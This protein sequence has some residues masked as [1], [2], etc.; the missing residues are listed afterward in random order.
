MMV[1]PSPQENAVFTADT[2]P[3]YEQATDEMTFN[4]STTSKRG[5]EVPAEALQM[6]EIEKTA[7]GFG[8]NI[9]GGIDNP[10]FTGDI[11]IYVSSVNHQSKSFGV[12]Q[13]GDKILSF[14]GIDM[15][16][17][18]HDEAVDVF[19]SMKVGHVAKML[20]DRE[21]VLL[22]ED[23][24]QSSA[25]PTRSVSENVSGPVTPQTESTQNQTPKSIPLSES[26]SRLT[27]H[28]F[29]A[30]IE[31]IR[32]KVY[33]EEDAQSVTSYA[34]ST[35]SIIDDVPRTPRKPLSLLDPRNNSWITEALYVSIGLG[36]LTLSGFLV[37]RFIKGRKNDSKMKKTEERKV[38]GAGLLS[39]S[40]SRTSLKFPT[41]AGYPRT[42]DHCH[43]D[44]TLEFQTS[45][46]FARHIR[47]DHTT[48]EGGSFLCRYG[49][50]GVC[51]KL[52]LEGVCDEDFEAHIRRCH[53]SSQPGRQPSPTS[54]GIA[55][56][57]EE[58]DAAS[59][60]SVRLTSE[61]PTREKKKFTLHR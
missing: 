7:N 17:K 3:V 35:H 22:Q 20:I 5:E 55:S 10:H 43:G 29:S 41:E 42:C 11:G 50:H 4:D 21:Y 27:A 24:T 56:W 33:E 39:A 13:T 34:P 53:T 44:L 14:D 40:S 54:S 32:G 2:E 61:T 48:Q 28:G 15:T 52:P 6:V 31:R 60:R 36:A 16:Y 9:V 25:T 57:A 1:S 46:E 49:E 12:I 19:R 51:Q 38:S 18:T 30:V 58:S 8:F 47:Q 26:K 23:R 37:Y 45:S 59:L